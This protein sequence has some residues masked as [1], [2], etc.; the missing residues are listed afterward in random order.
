MVE[1]IA[2]QIMILVSYQKI[3]RKWYNDTRNE[4]RQKEKTGF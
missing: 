1:I 4:E 3:L 2:I